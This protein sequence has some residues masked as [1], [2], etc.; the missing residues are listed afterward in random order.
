MACNDKL[1]FVGQLGVG[2]GELGVAAQIRTGFDFIGNPEDFN[3]NFQL[4]TPNFQLNKSLFISMTKQL[5]VNIISF[6]ANP[7]IPCR[8]ILKPKIFCDGI[9]AGEGDGV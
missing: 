4:P 3:H 8:F 6:Y 2:S 7:P 1:E 5:R 9:A